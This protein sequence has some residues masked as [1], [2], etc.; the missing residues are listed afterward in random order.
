LAENPLLKIARVLGGVVLMRGRLGHQVL[1]QML[2][3]NTNEVAVAGAMVVVAASSRQRNAVAQ[4]ALRTVAPALAVRALL[5]K[6]EERLERQMAL[7]VERERS[8][9]KRDE[10]VSKREREMQAPEAAPTETTGIARENRE[11]QRKVK[12]LSRRLRESHR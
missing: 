5:R 9:E 11:L 12:R 10:A 1:G 8:L 3:M 6:Q 7:L 4:V 2:V